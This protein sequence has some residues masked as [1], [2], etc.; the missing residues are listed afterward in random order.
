MMTICFLSAAF[1][2]SVTIAADGDEQ[3]VEQISNVSTFEFFKV[4]Q[5]SAAAETS[6]TRSQI[7]SEAVESE[8]PFPVPD[9]LI[10]T[11]ISLLTAW[12]GWVLKWLFD[13]L[14][15]GKSAT[16]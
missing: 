3:Q 11:I 8:E 1:S 15:R 6:K 10:E 16:T 14:K 4:A 5:L 9:G 2:I 12:F 7:R 13:R